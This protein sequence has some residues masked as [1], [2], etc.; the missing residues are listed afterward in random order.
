MKPLFWIAVNLIGLIIVAFMIKNK[1][2]RQAKKNHGQKLFG[3]IQ[4]VI[5]LYLIFDTG[6]SLMN[7]IV[8][9]GSKTL[10]YMFSVIYYFL[11][12]VLGLIY[13]IYCDYKVYNDLTGL[14]KRV[15]YY[16]I[17]AAVNALVVF[18]TPIT[19]MLFIIDEN[20]IYSRGEYFW[21]TIIAG[22]SYLACYLLLTIKTDKKQAISPKGSNIYLYLFPIPPVIFGI[23]QIYFS[24]ILL[25]GIGYIISVYFLY[26]NNIQSSEDKRKLAV[27]FNNINITHFAT[28]S[29]V[30][31]IGLFFT[32]EYIISEIP[33]EYAGSIQRKLM[34]PFGLITFLFIVF[35]FGSNRITKQLIFT[36]LQL[37]VESLLCLKE[38]M[39]EIYGIDRDDEIGTLSKTIKD[40]FIKGYYDGLTGIYNRRYM[41]LTL[42]QIMTVLSS[43]EAWLSVMIVD[44]DFF[45]KYN[46]VYG[47]KKGDDCL[48]EIAQVLNK[49]IVRKG[50]FVAR[51]GG[52]EFA[53]VLPGADAKGANIIANK[54]LKAIRALK[55]P[56]EKT[57]NGIVTVSIGITSGRQTNIKSW[58]EYIEKADEA[59]YMS[60]NNGRD[61]STFITLSAA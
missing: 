10:N 51:Y 56:H 27:R 15:V 19:K 5:M 23:I 58:N 18:L 52:E 59:L 40:L 53:I 48:R 46:D 42:H 7:G 49:N 47:H 12:P 50:D 29:F 38:N 20:N 41:E 43:T 35:I 1:D 45:K 32:F 33:H 55:I 34:L 44:V 22:Y 21:I 30:L 61:R 16:S 17:P 28:I 60:K 9:T 6:M 24:D 31:I 39:N 2:K 26:T 3:W 4:I 54:M 8:F 11:T 36:P 13:I 14:K 57:I 25:L 37:L